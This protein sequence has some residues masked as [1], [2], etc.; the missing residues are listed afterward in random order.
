MSPMAAREETPVEPAADAI[1]CAGCGATCEPLEDYPVDIGG[2]E[3]V[4]RA[5]RCPACGSEWVNAPEI[6]RPDRDLRGFVAPS[7]ATLG[8][9]RRVLSLTSRDPDFRYRQGDKVAGTLLWH[10]LEEDLADV[11]FLA[12]QSF[13]EGP[14]M[15]FTKKELLDAGQIR[16]GPG[17]AIA[18]GGGLRANLL[19]LA[20]LRHFAAVDGGLHPRVAVMGRPCQI[21]T[22]QK[23]LWD[24]FLPGYELAF[25]LGTF[26]YGNFAPALSGGQ[27][28]R[29]LLG[30]DPSEIRRVRFLG[31]ELEFTSAGGQRRAVG[32]GDVAGLVNANC[33]QCYDF[34]VTF[35]DLSVGHVGSGE[36]FEA[37]LVRTE[38][39][40]QIMN[41]A[42]GDGLVAPAAQLYG[43]A[44]IGEEER[45]ALSFLSAMVDIKRELT[46]W[47]R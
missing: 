5:S 1:A 4:F 19:T 37:A 16:M 15:A 40:E 28:L 7:V 6:L 31:E 3:V 36:L 39:G 18:T 24:R 42:M 38:R 17:R 13:G 26:C 21:Y 45:R 46:R 43:P 9:Y 27:K 20:Q 30:F 2:A 12:H 47:I 32:L 23:L 10:L 8:S 41:Q 25:A 35:S 22:V 44:E 14:A 11:V 34:S 29:A 33:L